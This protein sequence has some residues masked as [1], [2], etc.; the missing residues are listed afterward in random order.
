MLRELRQNFPPW[1]PEKFTSSGAP[2]W[3]T[4]TGEMATEASLP[5][6]A[7]LVLIDLYW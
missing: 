3:A 5:A 4:R 1:V 2:I 6:L 7:R